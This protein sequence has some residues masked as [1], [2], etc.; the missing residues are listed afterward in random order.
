VTQSLP[1]ERASLL[2]LHAEARRRRDRAA[3]GGPEF[4]AACVEIAAIEVQ[5]ARIEQAPMAPIASQP[6]PAAKPGA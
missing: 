3:L 6:A 5:I 4:R 1:D 2:I